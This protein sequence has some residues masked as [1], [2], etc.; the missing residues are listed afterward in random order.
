M[1]DQDDFY[2][3]C[4]DGWHGILAEVC[5]RMQGR[6]IKIIQAKEKFGGLRIYLNNYAPYRICCLEIVGFKNGE[7]VDKSTPESDILIKFLDNLEYDPSKMD[8][9]EYFYRPDKDQF[10]RL[11]GYLEIVKLKDEDFIKGRLSQLT[12]LVEAIPIE[13]EDVNDIIAWAESESF[14]TCEMC[15]SKENVTIQGNWIKTLCADC[16]DKRFQS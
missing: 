5:R 1:I 7:F 11:R 14:K 15:G 6:G 8:S 10:Y 16:H 9:G 4:G 12:G 2:A 3:E 13:E